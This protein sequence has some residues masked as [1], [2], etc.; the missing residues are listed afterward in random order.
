MAS[1]GFQSVEYPNEL[2]VLRRE[3]VDW[4]KSCGNPLVWHDAALSC[5]LFLGDEHGLVPWLCEQSGLDRTTA[6]CLFLHRDVGIQKL[7]G[8]P[9][10]HHELGA[11]QA[12]RIVEQ[13]CALDRTNPLPDNGIAAPGDG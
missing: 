11:L 5:I 9:V 13:L 10:E 7:L 1:V 8:L 4:I 3:D 2:S 6:V 12:E